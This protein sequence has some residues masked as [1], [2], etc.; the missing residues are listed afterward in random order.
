M[1]VTPGDAFRIELLD[2]QFYF[3]DAGS[4]TWVRSRTALLVPQ[5][6]SGFGTV[7]VPWNPAFQDVTVHHLDILRGDERIDAL[8]G[9]D[10]TVL[11]REANLETAI[12]DG[13]LTATLQLDGLRV[14]DRLEFAYSVTSQ[15]PVLGSHIEFVASGNF[16]AMIDQ[17]FLRGSWPTASG[18]RI[19]ASDD[20][21]T[22]QIRRQGNRSEIEIA[23]A[24]LEPLKVPDDAPLRF[25]RLRQ[26]EGSDYRSWADL[27]AVFAPLYADASVLAPDSPLRA[28]AV[29]IRDSHP[30]TAGQ[31]LAALRLV[32]DDVRYLALAMGE[33][34]LVPAT[35]DQTW[36]QRLGDCKGKTAL[37]LALLR[38]LGVDARPVLAHVLDRELDQQLPAVSAFNHVFV[39]AVVDGQTVWLDGTRT[40]DRALAGPVPL[41]YGWVLPVTAAGA[42][43]VHMPAHPPAEALR[44]SSL[45]IDLTD[46]LYSA[47]P[48]TGEMIYRGDEAALLQLQF[49]VAPPAQRESF[50]R[51]VWQGLLRSAEIGEVQSA[52]DVEQN[53]LRLTMTGT[54]KLDWTS[55]GARRTEIPISRINWGVRDRR[56]DGPFRDLPTTTS[57]P[58]YSRFRTTIILPGEGE[59]FIVDAVDVD[60]QVAAYRHRRRTTKD[61]AR[62]VMERD[63]LALR[64]EVTEAERSEAAGALRRISGLRAEIAAPASYEATF[65]DLNALE[66]D[67]PQTATAWV[68][69]GL[70]LNDNNRADEAIAA[71]ARAIA[72]DPV[73]ANAWA[74]R[75]IIRFWSGEFDAAAADFDKA[76]ELDSSE[77]VAL[78]GRGLIALQEERYLDAVV[79]FS[80]LLRSWPDDY[81]AL[82][83]RAHA[84][85]GMKEWDKAL[86]DIRRTRDLGSEPL[87]MDL[88]EVSVLVSAGRLEEA[89]VAMD[90]VIA[91]EPPSVPLW[92]MQAAVR[93]KRGDLAGAEASLTQALELEPDHPVVLI[94]RAGYRFRLNNP[95][96]AQDDMAAARPIADQSAS[97]LNNLCWTRAVA[98]V[99]LEQALADCDAALVLRPDFASTFDSR[100]MVLMQL[101][102]LPEALALYDRALAMEPDQAASLYGRGLVR[103]ALGQADAGR[104]DKEAARRLAPD[105]GDDFE[106]YEARRAE[107]P[108]P[109]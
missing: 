91:R 94:A 23:S 5:A 9:K 22:P 56:E 43:L 3:D 62:I 107:A 15:T 26:I 52:Y 48:V 10:F 77:R 87:E 81:F 37:L 20:W 19:R 31:V 25:H 82:E 85:A 57:Y 4:H 106:V 12:L 105:V 73:N 34:G 24:R 59:G 50:M 58:T 69:R 8:A 18:V 11:R 108:A 16:P 71:F 88:R 45:E 109:L 98:G 14:G 74:N 97:L 30:T 6:L 102:R 64:P 35:A 13:V 7:A 79:E 61:G 90:A 51:V 66:T 41:D 49:S 36:E 76:L 101:G 70:A 27:A 53:Q 47:A 28:Q 84:Y 104:T 67:E 93:E 54:V 100:A 103:E 78:N 95:A 65:D 96:G 68:K 42:A 39:Q 17:Y 99:E 63:T 29:R 40:G 75:G 38:E 80:M 21:A 55:R 46:G 1:P 86:I 89:S 83:Y 60:E 32:Q 2:Q 92:Q 33:G 72:L 44:E